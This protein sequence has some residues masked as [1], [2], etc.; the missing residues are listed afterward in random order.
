MTFIIAAMSLVV[1]GALTVETL[2]IPATLALGAWFAFA[3][4]DRYDAP[5]DAHEPTK[6]RRN[7][8]VRRLAGEPPSSRAAWLDALLIGSAL[9]LAVLFVSFG[10]RGVVVA[11]VGCAAAW[12]YSGRPL[13]FKARPGV[14]LLTHAGFVETFPYVTAIV[15]AGAPLLPIDL[16]AWAIL[17]LT[18]L[19]AQLE[20]QA[21]DYQ[22]DSKFER[23]FTIVAGL[24]ANHRL[25]SMASILLVFV[26]TA[27]AL[28]GIIPPLLWPG[29]ALTLP[30]IAHRLTRAPG[31]PRNE[32]L[33]RF[34]LAGGA[35]YLAAVVAA[36]L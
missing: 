24:H 20:Q 4:N 26:G 8:F 2:A 10:L 22:L 29:M 9:V 25:M 3:I 7:A 15:L 19:S 33:M 12:A 1:R 16:I 14:D 30:M 28:A 34:S 6:A 5:Y 11:F 17:A 21:R 27:G 36:T 32:M 31:T 35:V 23:N 18:S 13:R